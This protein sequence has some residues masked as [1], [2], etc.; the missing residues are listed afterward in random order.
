M[1][2]PYAWGSFKTSN[3]PAQVPAGIYQFLSVRYHEPGAVWYDNSDPKTP[4]QRK[5]YRPTRAFELIGDAFEPFEVKSGEFLYIGAVS[6]RKTKEVYTENRKKSKIEALITPFSDPNKRTFATFNVHDESLEV[7]KRLVQA[8]ENISDKFTVRLIKPLSTEDQ[9]SQKFERAK[10]RDSLFEST[11]ISRKA[12]KDLNKFTKKNGS[13]NDIL[14][15]N[16]LELF[17][18]Y[19]SK[20]RTLFTTRRD[21]L[22]EYINYYGE[23]YVLKSKP[24][25]LE[26][27]RRL[28]AVL[29][30]LVN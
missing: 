3:I 4:P 15:K 8:N 18:S 30:G 25:L 26:E 17:R 6:S 27:K 16:D 21:F 14:K 12:I 7:K 10:N 28:D 23:E 9:L 1:T 13:I 11:T 20:Y 22:S 2:P 5:Q 19:L 24:E 29:K